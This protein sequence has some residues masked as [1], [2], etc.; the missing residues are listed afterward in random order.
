MNYNSILFTL[1]FL[2]ISIPLFANTSNLLS[3]SSKIKG[4]IELSS[5]PDLTICNENKYQ[6]LQNQLLH[7]PASLLQENITFF[8]HAEALLQKSPESINYQ[9]YLN[10]QTNN[11]GCFFSECND[12]YCALNRLRST[13]RDAFEQKAFELIVQNFP[14]KNEPLELVSFG[15]SH[16]MPELIIITKLINAGYNN[17]NIHCIDI[18]F[19]EY[20]EIIQ[21]QP[22]HIAANLADTH[23]QRQAWLRSLTYLF[24]QTCNYLSWL[25]HRP[26][27][28]NIYDSV[29]T[30]LRLNKEATIVMGIDYCETFSG[31]RSKIRMALGDFY[32][33]SF[34]SCKNNGLILSN[35]DLP[36][37]EHFVL[38][39][40][41]NLSP[42]LMQVLSGAS[43]KMTI[44]LGKALHDLCVK[45]KQNI[46]S[47]SFRPL[48][49]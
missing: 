11:P 46:L 6:K 45:K 23:K 13:R 4:H 5:V 3:F 28:I 24:H 22:K 48:E 29:D 40:V 17:I 35:I 41:G 2:G 25:S 14:N 34:T 47:N 44:D 49:L 33:L 43:Q 36:T 19:Q 31:D 20:I 10:A 37:F 38:K 18:A 9:W 15:S 39:K 7:N 32:K 8:T 42:A 16:L 26:I 27:S 30:Y 1:I 21:K 12:N